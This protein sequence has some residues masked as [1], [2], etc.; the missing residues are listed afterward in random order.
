MRNGVAFVFGLKK[1]PC[2]TLCVL[3]FLFVGHNLS[4]ASESENAEKAR[5]LFSF[6]KFMQWPTRASNSLYLCSYGKTHLDSELMKYEGA[7]ALGRPV[8]VMTAVEKS[9]AQKCH[10][11]FISQNNSE[12][13]RS[14][15]YSLQDASIVTVG[16]IKGF[17][18]KG[19]MIEFLRHEDRLRFMIN[20][21]L[22]NAKSVEI[23]SKLL[24]LGF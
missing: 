7:K 8:V 24:L 21:E 20:H 15:L 9:N 5:Y 23:D 12:D 18:Y 10:I 19:G 3:S 16:D 2:I 17:S 14:T 13:W 22:A 6:L 11:I 1:L 4:A